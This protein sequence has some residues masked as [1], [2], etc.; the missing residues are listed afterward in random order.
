MDRQTDP[1][2]DVYIGNWE[3]ALNDFTDTL[4]DLG[5][6]VGLTIFDREDGL[7]GPL[8]V[9]V[10]AGTSETQVGEIARDVAIRFGVDP[11]QMLNVEAG[12]IGEG[13][14]GREGGEG[15]EV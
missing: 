10:I 11:N 8:M 14:E 6:Y 13:R 15:R 2:M 9:N 12:E 5:Y 4:E 1:G 3:Q 7:E